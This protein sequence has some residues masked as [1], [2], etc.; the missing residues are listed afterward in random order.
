MQTT[1]DTETFNS[2]HHEMLILLKIKCVERR[3]VQQKTGRPM[4][5]I[6]KPPRDFQKVTR[7]YSPTKHIVTYGRAVSYF[8]ILGNPSV[9]T[10]S[11]ELLGAENYHR[12]LPCNL[13]CQ[14]NLN[15]SSVLYQLV[16]VHILFRSLEFFPVP[17][18][19][20]RMRKKALIRVRNRR[21]FWNDVQQAGN[22]RGPQN[23]PETEIDSARAHFTNC[24]IHAL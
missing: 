20:R 9:C 1:D 15:H 21:D 11:R 22:T 14:I 4:T 17:C 10:I 7:P 24:F 5:L 6:I 13:S 3:G 12:N 16:A 19:L 23:G 8:N 2:R 18:L